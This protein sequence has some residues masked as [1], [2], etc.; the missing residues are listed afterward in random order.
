M[1]ASD[2]GKKSESDGSSFSSNRPLLGET[3]GHWAKSRS[4]SPCVARQHSG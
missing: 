1:L 3:G 4:S 2:R